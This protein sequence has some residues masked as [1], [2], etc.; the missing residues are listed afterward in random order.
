MI[1]ELWQRCDR[2][3]FGVGAIENGTLLSPKLVS[4]EELEALK[5]LN[6]VGDVLGHCFDDEGNF[7]NSE[8]EDRLVSIPIEL[9]MKIPDR[10]AVAL[11]G[12]KVPA[13]RGALRS[14]IITELFTDEETAQALLDGE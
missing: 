7:I 13:L 12:Y 1:Y 8:L 9:F 10:R 5:E 6:A 11:G 2:A 3:I 14:G 4:E